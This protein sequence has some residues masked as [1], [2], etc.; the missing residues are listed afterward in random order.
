M[1]PKQVLKLVYTFETSMVMFCPIL[2]LPALHLTC[3]YLVLS[4]LILRPTFLVS[5]MFTNIYFASFICKYK[6]VKKNGT[7][8]F[9]VIFELLFLQIDLLDFNFFEDKKVF[10]SSF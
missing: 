3:I 1:E 6:L 9:L 8:T 7:A 4:S 5:S 2:S 10:S